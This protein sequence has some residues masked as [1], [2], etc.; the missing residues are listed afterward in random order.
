MKAPV[1]VHSLS[2]QTTGVMKRVQYAFCIVLAVLAGDAGYVLAQGTATYRVIFDATWSAQTHPQDFPANPHFSGIIGG[3]HNTNVTFWEPGQLASLGIKNMAE[4]GSKA[5][6]RAE[7]EQAIS[8]GHANNVIDEGGIGVSPNSRTFEITV[9]PFWPLVTMTSML[10]PSP[11]WFVGT[12]GL[13]LLQDGYWLDTLEVDAFVYDAGTD[14][15]VSYESPNDPTN[16]PENIERIETEPFLVSG[17]VKPVGTFRFELVSVDIASAGYYSTSSKDILDENG[18]PVEIKGIGLGGW[19]VPEGYMF[20][21]HTTGR[22]DG[23][24]AIRDQIVELIGQANADEFYQLFRKHFVAEK[25][26]AAIKSWG[27][28]HIRLPFHYRDFYDPNT[29]S[30]DEA[31]FDFLDTFLGWCRTHGLW[32][33]LD[34][35]AAPGAQSEGG[36]ADSDGEARLWT[37]KEKY[38]PQ[39]IKIWRE[40]ARRYAKE[41]VIIGYDFINEPVTPVSHPN[42]ESKDLRTLYE[43]IIK[44]VRPIDPNHLFFI[45]G[46]YWATDFGDLEPHL[47]EKTVYTFHKYWNGT[48]QNSIQY[49]LDLR[50]RQ[51]IPLWLGETGE[52]SNPWFHAVTNLMKQHAIGINWWTHK[53]VETTTSPLSAPFAPG[54]KDVIEYWRGNAPKPTLEY[55]RDALF[56]M[57]RGLDLDSCRVNQGLLESLLNPDFSTV[58][59]PVKTHV[60][61]G[62]IAASDYDIGT[63]G[64]TYHD[65]G[66]MATDG[67]PG[68]GNNGHKYRNDGVDIEVSSDTLGNGYNVGWTERL[69]WLTYTVEV[70]EDEDYDIDVRVASNVD[71][72]SL[73]LLMNDEPLHTDD[74]VV[75]NTGG[76]QAWQTRTISDVALKA[77][78]HILKILITGKDLNLNTLGFRESNPT[79]IAE[80]EE[81]PV[82]PELQAVYPNPSGDVINIDFVVARPGHVTAALYDVLGRRVFETVQKR[83]SRGSNTVELRTGVVPGVYMLRVTVESEGVDAHHFTQ[84]VVVMR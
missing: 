12:R 2:M 71:G 74:I 29:D 77:G 14:S 37:E 78:T 54:Y 21:I 34:M 11:D 24:T 79:G 32:V 62:L 10:A 19:L 18:D 50:D 83:A 6:L 15:G 63:E 51:D 1:L 47:G 45:E 76:W 7:V 26:I 22:P 44:A 58:R 35:H 16:P 57:A 23:P 81:V 65:F 20:H 70:T 80:G 46:N 72:G 43:E 40:I 84:S 69:E 68:G 53:K 3:T 17:A 31:G 60:I 27:F 38:W 4:L 8:D 33:I 59:I 13:A 52:N 39:T 41:Q 82:R 56:A 55:A 25:D 73:R 67:T 49:L 30:F 9:H 28:D 48:G 64:V 61:P 42:V 75:G 66:V 5:A 36:I